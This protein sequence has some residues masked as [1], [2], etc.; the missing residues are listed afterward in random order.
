MVHLRFITSIGGIIT[1]AYYS[2]HIGEIRVL[3]YRH[4]NFDTNYLA[5]AVMAG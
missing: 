2:V 3:F 1:R 4:A 5:L